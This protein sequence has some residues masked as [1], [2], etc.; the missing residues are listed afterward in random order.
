MVCTLAAVTF[1]HAYRIWSN[2]AC[3]LT[4]KVGLRGVVDVGTGNTCGEISISWQICSGDRVLQA[5]ALRCTLCFPRELTYLTSM[6][7]TIGMLADAHPWA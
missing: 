2:R 1:R 5:T 7:P 6:L 3:M 4:S